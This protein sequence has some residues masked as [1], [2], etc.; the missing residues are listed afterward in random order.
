MKRTDIE[1]INRERKK[2][3]KKEKSLERG[4]EVPTAGDIIKQLHS[5]FFFDGQ[6]IYNIDDSEEILECIEEMKECVPERKW[7]DVIKKAVKK[8]GV[9]DKNSAISKLNELAEI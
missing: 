1:R 6:Q 8:T 4:K 7:D 5:L 2:T 3:M 9:K